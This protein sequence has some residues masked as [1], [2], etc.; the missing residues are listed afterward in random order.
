[1]CFAPHLG[2]SFFG[3]SLW[4]IRIVR[5]TLKWLWCKHY[6]QGWS[7]NQAHIQ[8]LKSNHPVLY[9][10]YIF[11]TI[12]QIWWRTQHHAASFK[13][14]R[15]FTYW[16]YGSGRRCE[17]MTTEAPQV[18]A[19]PQYECAHRSSTLLLCRMEWSERNFRTISWANCHFK[20]AFIRL[21]IYTYWNLL[22]ADGTLAGGLPFNSAAAQLTASQAW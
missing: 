5:S 2:G 18:T 17:L 19:D 22:L 6:I 7:W 15:C 8:Y 14:S 1:M 12:D 16:M 11:N 10:Y 21:K 9:T 3:M 13:R 20:H 4:K